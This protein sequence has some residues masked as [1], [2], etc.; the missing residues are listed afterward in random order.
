MTVEGLP[1]ATAM[2]WAPPQERELTIPIEEEKERRSFG[3]C[4]S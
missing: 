1:G 4:S 2:T 3:V